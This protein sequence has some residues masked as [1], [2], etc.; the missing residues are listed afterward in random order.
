MNSFKD[1]ARFEPDYILLLRRN[2]DISYYQQ[3]QIFVEPKGTYLLEKDKS[4][5]VGFKI[6]HLLLHSQD[7]H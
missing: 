4:K 6:R 7:K 3:Q 2:N 1:G 5:Q